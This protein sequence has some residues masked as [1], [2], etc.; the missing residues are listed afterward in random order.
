MLKICKFFLS[1]QN[2]L[3]GPYQHIANSGRR[4]HLYGNLNVVTKDNLK[5]KEES[6]DVQYFL[7]NDLLIFVVPDQIFFNSVAKWKI[8]L[9]VGLDEVKVE[10]TPGTNL[11]EITTKNVEII[12]KFQNDEKKQ[13]L[14]KLMDTLIQICRNDKIGKEKQKQ[15][16]QKEH[17]ISTKDPKPANPTSEAKKPSPEASKDMKE[18]NGEKEKEKSVGEKLKKSLSST[19][20]HIKEELIIAKKEIKEGVS[21]LN[22][23]LRN[24][25]LLSKS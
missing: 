24:K 14:F 20:N 11:V 4:L 22:N 16:E 13:K 19:K 18:P 17:N 5:K 23:S 21:E 8:D 25:K 9:M 1:L 15:L 3:S 2:Q 10:L 12:V 6:K 7:F